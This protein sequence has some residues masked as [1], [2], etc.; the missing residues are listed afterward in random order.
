MEINGLAGGNALASRWEKRRLC[1]VERGWACAMEQRLLV[2]GNM[3]ALR[4]GMG[5]PGAVQARSLRG[6]NG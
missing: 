3:M 5:W 1:A 6:G 2:G 4:A